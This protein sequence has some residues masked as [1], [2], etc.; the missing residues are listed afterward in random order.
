VPGNSR[1]ARRETCRIIAGQ[2][3]IGT[4]ELGPG[5]GFFVGADMPYTDVPGEKGVEVLE[6]R[7]SNHFDLKVL[8]NNADYWRNALAGLQRDRQAWP[9]QGAPPSG[10]EIP[11]VQSGIAGI[12]GANSGMPAKNWR[13]VRSRH[14]PAP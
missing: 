11:Q 14:L 13:F 4:E 12:C 1:G 8:A 6:F 5:D 10:I 7:D 2:L 3:R 9:A